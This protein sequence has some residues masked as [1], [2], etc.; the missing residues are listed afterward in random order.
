[1]ADL[2]PILNDEQHAEYIAELA[3]LLDQYGDVEPDS[4]VGQRLLALA[5]IIETYERKRWPI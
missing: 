4:D 2:P 1:M 5:T 3:Q